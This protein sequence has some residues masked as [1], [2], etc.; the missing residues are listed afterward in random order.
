MCGSAALG[1]GTETLLEDMIEC[2]PSPEN[3]EPI[4][5]IDLKTNEEKEFKI[6]EDAPFSAFV[7]KTVADPFIGKLSL[8]R[9][10]SGKVKADSL[11][12]NTAKDKQEKFGSLYFVRGKT[13]ISANE[14]V[15]GDIGAVAKLQ[16]TGYRGY[17]M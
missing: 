3:T 7:F 6:S 2:F 8:F 14:I 12:Y 16:Y 17:S 4:E 5:V 1:V 15:A 9:V 11:V 10:M 13:Q